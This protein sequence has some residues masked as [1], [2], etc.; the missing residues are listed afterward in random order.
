MTE[1]PPLLPDPG[2]ADLVELVERLARW[3]PA[4]L[5]E[6]DRAASIVAACRTALSE[7]EVSGGSSFA[8]GVAR[9]EAAAQCFSRHLLL[10]VDA[11]G[12]LVPD[13]AD[14]GWP[15]PDPRQVR[16]RG[17]GVGAVTRTAD[18]VVTI[19]VDSLEA[20]DLAE[21]QIDAAITL[22]QGATGVILDLRRN[23]GGD[24]GTVARLAGFVLGHPPVPLSSVHQRHGEQVDW[25]SDPPP[26][27]MC[28]PDGVPVAVL[29]SARTFSSAEAL[30]YHLRVRGRAVVIGEATPGAADHVSPFVLTRFVHAQ[31][32]VARVVDAVTGANWEATGV[33]PDVECAP[34]QAHDVAVEWL[35]ARVPVGD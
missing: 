12:T 10:F 28:V 9:I 15:P 20:I 3:V 2:A 6:P 26:A 14:H 4:L 30:A 1:Q 32:P 19:E 8:E 27:G 11:A 18:G 33:R 16:R 17:G 13:D 25:V 5:D 22:A 34:E 7:I 29:I 21:P 31:L 35:R 23:G 24:P